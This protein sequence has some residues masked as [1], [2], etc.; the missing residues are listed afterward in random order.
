MKEVNINVKFNATK[1]L[2][3]FDCQGFD[4]NIEKIFTIIGILENIKQQNIDQLNILLK[5]GMD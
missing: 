2:T 4:N 5:H 3:S 1:V